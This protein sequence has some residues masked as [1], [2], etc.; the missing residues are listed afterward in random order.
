MKL[1]KII[2]ICILIFT[3]L[4]V[5]PISQVNAESIRDPLEVPGWYYPGD[6][7]NSGKLADI[8]KIIISV[9]Q[10]I[11]VVASVVGLIILGLRYMMGSVEEKAN[12]KETMIPYLIGIFML[13]GITT[14]LQILYNFFIN[15]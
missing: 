7:S 6:N 12:Y 13:F 2:I 5:I 8:G 1:N 14:L 10:T 4:A 11:G 9:I 3:I 15:I